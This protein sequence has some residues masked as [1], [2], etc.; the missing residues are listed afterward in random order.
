MC[1]KT[2]EA[3]R[4]SLKA[5]VGARPRH[6]TTTNEGGDHSQEAD[7]TD[8]PDER[9][10]GSRDGGEQLA[11]GREEGRLKL[12]KLQTHQPHDVHLYGP[13]GRHR[14]RQHH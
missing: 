12:L 6:V 2:R 3:G 9:I 7:W 14:C 5:D 1:G 4:L 11:V 8:E 13:S 10:A